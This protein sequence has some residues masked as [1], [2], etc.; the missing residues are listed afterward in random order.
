M[1]SVSCT[2]C[3]ATLPLSL[4]CDGAVSCA[5][6]GATTELPPPLRARIAEGR[7]VL[8]QCAEHARQLDAASRKALA[9][10]GRSVALTVASLLVGMV[11]LAACALGGVALSLTAGGMSTSLLVTMFVPFAFGGLAGLA[12]ARAASAARADLERACAARP[13][14]GPSEAGRCRVCGAGLAHGPES[15]ARCPYC[16]ADNLVAGAAV[17]RAARGVER[18]YASEADALRA[19]ATGVLETAARV[20]AR[21]L[22]AMFAAPVV[23]VVLLVVVVSVMHSVETDVHAEVQYAVVAQPDGRR[24]VARVTPYADHVRISYGTSGLAY[25]DRPNSAGL[26]L[27]AADAVVAVGTGVFAPTTVAPG[28]TVARVYGTLLGE[29]LAEIRLADGT[30]SRAVIEGLCLAL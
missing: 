10:A 2:S 11:P 16:K 26:A 23:T 21:S 14:L 30:S 15:V 28:A 13:P 1:Q 25:A 19:R 20:R 9:R 29:N 22:A 12:G 6:C 7:A 24:C 18:A 4:D 3:G 17:E 27:V 8:A 5:H